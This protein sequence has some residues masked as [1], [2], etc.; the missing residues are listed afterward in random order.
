MDDTEQTPGS[1]SVSGEALIPELIV[2]PSII[3]DAIGLRQTTPVRTV[4]EVTESPLDAPGSGRRLRTIE[5]VSL[6]SSRLQIVQDDSVVDQDEEETTPMPTQRK[7][8]R[9]EPFAKEASLD[10]SQ[11]LFV[12]AGNTDN[13]DIDELSPEQP[14]R[15]SKRTKRSAPEPS[16]EPEMDEEA[17]A[18]AIDDEQV[19]VLLNKNKRRRSSRIFPAASPE[20]DRPASPVAK[21]RK[22]RHRVDSS[23]VQQRQPKANPKSKKKPPKNQLKRYG[24]PIPVTVHRLTRLKS[25]IYDD[26][27]DADIFNARIPRPKR[28]DPNAV[29][30]LSQVCQEIVTSTLESLEEA[31]NR[32]EDAAIRREFKTK[33]DAVEAY[34]RELQTRLLEHV[35][36]SVDIWDSF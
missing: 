3:P 26:D 13:A 32:S 21:T 18:E 22:S 8:K 36:S 15:G 25:I 1:A 35:C 12:K 17:E 20:L 6:A 9:K 34:G 27:T 29:D 5:K 19:A 28:G 7:R 23:P 31:G 24:S 33:Y 2:E 16:P 14:T 4:E 30:V 10:L 11:E